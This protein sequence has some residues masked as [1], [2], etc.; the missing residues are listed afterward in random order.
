VRPSPL[1]AALLLS[2]APAAGAAE[3]EAGE[4]RRAW[5]ALSEEDLEAARAVVEPLLARRPGD[6]AV[7]AVGGLL[8]FQEQR[9]A[10]AVELLDRAGEV[11]AGGVDW[12]RLARA[13]LEVTRDHVKT[14]SEHFRV[15]AAPGKDQVLVPYLLETLEA[16]RT[17]LE[18][19]LGW[20]PPAKVTVEVL[21]GTQE[22]ARLSTLTVQEIRTSGTI[23]LCKFDKLMIVSPKALWQGYDWLDTAAHEYTHHVVTQ[24]TR[25]LTPIWLH[26]GLAKW[27]ESRWRGKGGLSFSPFAAALLRDASEKDKL[28]TFEQMHPSMA[29][30]P[31][32]EAAALA[33]AEVMVAVEY[34]VAHGG[35]P[36]LQRLLDLVARG[37]PA[38]QAVAETL[39]ISFDAFLADWKR[40][41]AARPLPAGGDTELRK[42]RF[43][44]DPKVGE[45]AEWADL[46]DE[47]ARG[48]ARL[49]EI[50][51][52][53]GR[54]DAA[55]VELARAMRRVGPRL[56][57]LTSK[58]AMAA[59]RSGHDAEAEG[60]LRAAAAAHPHHA[61]L[62][63]GLGRLALRRQDW[64]G[65]RQAF[66]LA[67]QIDPYDPEIH[68]GLAV[69]ADKLGQAALASREAG[70]ALILSGKAPRE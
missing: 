45:H 48:H 54:W 27:E 25:N 2:L 50:L 35:P 19:D 14:D 43:Q 40:W 8:R 51:R 57:L 31:S 15:S 42:L 56:P 32:Q 16:Q 60:A 23:A 64:A 63:V 44:D 26:E 29:K 24:R 28:I 6:P 53:R 47:R 41:L 9:Y 69:A 62:Q 10:E 1:L 34:L 20:V 70:F 7:A 4:L 36:A 46:P 5:Q 49:G 58:Y 68:A 38:D 37:R 13:T 59:M 18:Q 67:N 12:P 33:F 17:A 22:L 30:L 21:Q 39:G 66:L 61:A 11:S 55:R 65:A 52:E 3:Q